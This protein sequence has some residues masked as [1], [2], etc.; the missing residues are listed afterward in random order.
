M[1]SR[2]AAL[3]SKKASDSEPETTPLPQGA[4]REKRQTDPRECHRSY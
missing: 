4:T 3:T 2:Q 1:Q